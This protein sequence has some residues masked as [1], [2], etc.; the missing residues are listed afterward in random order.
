MGQDGK[1]PTKGIQK[2]TLCGGNTFGSQRLFPR[3]YFG[4][5]RD[6]G[7]VFGNHSERM[8]TA[9]GQDEKSPTKGIQST[10]FCGVMRF[11]ANGYFLAFISGAAE[12]WALCLV[13]ILKEVWLQEL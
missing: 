7:T 6:M 2:H 8:S 12:I 10:P 1:S 13:F 4:C 5:L 11:G 9:M 3:I